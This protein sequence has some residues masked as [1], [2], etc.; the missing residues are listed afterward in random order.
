MPTGNASLI[1]CLS[2]LARQVRGCTLQLLQ[3]ADATCLTWTPPGTS[4]HILWHAGHALWVQ[5]VLTVQPLTAL[6]ELP[7]GWSAKFGQDSRP[8][9]IKD[10]PNASEVRGQLE[11]QLS[12]VL[13]LFPK[14]AE[15]IASHANRTPAGGGWPLLA[16]IL[17]GWHDEARHQGEMYLL[18][19][20]ARTR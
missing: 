9:S 8:A 18:Q 1:P 19:K 13:E 7:R 12:R 17:H 5:D 6:S 3:P 11:M 16:G 15:T 20:L 4:N 10:W 2:E 14:H